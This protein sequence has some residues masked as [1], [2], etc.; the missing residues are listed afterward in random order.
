MADD[1]P[2]YRIVPFSPPHDD[3]VSI[4]PDDG[5]G[6]EISSPKIANDHS[7][8]ETICEETYTNSGYFGINSDISPHNNEVKS[9]LP[10]ERLRHME[11]LYQQHLIE[12]LP[13]YYPGISGCRSV[14]EFECLNKISEGTFGVVYRAKEKRT[15]KIVALKRLKMEKEHQGF[16]ITSLR[17][18]NMLL[19]CGN[20]PNVLNVS[21]VVVGSSM[22]KIY[23]VMEYIEHDIKSLM[24][25]ME[26]RK[27]KWTIPQVKT[28]M[29]Q[30]L[31]GIEH[32]HE[33]YVIH[34]DLK[35]S[36]LLLSHLGILK[37]GDFGL[38]REFG[39]PL[40][41]YTPIVVTLWYR[42]PELLLGTE[43]YS[44]PV[45]MW[46]IGCI[47]GE[48]LKLEPLFPGRTEIDQIQRIFRDIGTPIEQTWPGCMELPGMRNGVFVDTPFNQLHRKF[49]SAL[50]DNDGYQ[51]LIKL[52][53][54]DPSRRL[55][56][57]QA[58]ESKWFQ[59]NPKPLPPSA[60]P[61]WPAKSEH[62]KKPPNEPSAPRKP[63]GGFTLKFDPI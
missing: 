35:T 53:T 3:D 36:N 8:V 26:S 9:L 5:N 33:K 38:A 57:K 24:E 40:K 54:L 37:I 13:V 4:L 29:H 16:P 30:L 58:L 44:T 41:S 17:E 6:L 63:I 56:A 27:K 12:Q 46:S 22:D 49:S 20:H 11:E 2:Y 47:F 62:N 55:S 31:S 15:D 25:L 10:E 59:N 51:L 19:K 61:T 23:L 7:E 14:V 34:R 60:F 28:L 18:I 21:E 48:F 52:L 32:M 45:D 42:S 43:F 39:E 50:P 1:A